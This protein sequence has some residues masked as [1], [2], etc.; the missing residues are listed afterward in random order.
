M[1]DFDEKL[2]LQCGLFDPFGCMAEHDWE[3]PQSDA[4]FPWEDEEVSGDES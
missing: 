3:C 1:A 2:C 4:P